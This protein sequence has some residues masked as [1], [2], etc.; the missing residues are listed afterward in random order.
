MSFKLTSN[1]YGK[2]EV[3]LTK[4]IRNGNRHELLEFSVDIL[5]SGDFSRSYTDG[6]NTRVIA[7]DSMKNTVYVLAK[8]RQFTTPEEFAMLLAS[9]FPQMY[10]QVRSAFVQVNQTN[11]AR[12]S[13]DQQPHDHA[14]ICGGP[15][16]RT[17]HAVALRDSFAGI[18]GGVSDLLLLKTTRSAFKGF[19]TDRYRTLKDADD[20]IFATKLS[21]TWDFPTTTSATP[22]FNS[23]RQ[24]IQ[25]AMLNVF[26]TTMSHAVQQ[27]MYEMGQAALSAAPEITRI[28]LEMPNK[29][30]IPVNL[31][32]FGLENNNE[33]FVW[34]DEPYGLIT[35]TVDRE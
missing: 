19:V 1:H 4:V 25:S 13:V 8:E 28:E 12:I 32:P 14:F 30:R 29:H 3:R 31:Q 21:T 16:A 23:V 11:W 20:R 2:S 22:D 17:A 9:H 27:T 18:S 6:D 10:P 35:A 24:R 26:A 34:T 5:L 7:T 15:D 33:I